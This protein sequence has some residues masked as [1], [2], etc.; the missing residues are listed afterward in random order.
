MSREKQYSR[1]ELLSQAIAIFRRNGYH[2]TSTAELTR[3]LGINKK[4][5][6]AEFG[7]KLQ[8]FE[9]TLV[10]YDRTFLT[11]MLRPIEEQGA[12]AE[13]IK[14]VFQQIAEY[15]Q[16]EL[17]GLGCLLCNTSAERG[18]LHAC[19]GPAI[20]HYYERINNGLK[21]ALKNYVSS[22]KKAKQID[23]NS[24]AGF[25]TT[26]L[27]GMATSARA[28]APRQQLQATCRFIETYLDSLK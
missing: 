22:Q 26:T 2:A 28:E 25:L 1:E 13:G 9:N 21:H 23:V 10:Y 3:E 14:K 11:E 27:I 16:K 17:K 15:G 5:M 8:F 4:T 20:D 24:I 6:Y 19:I 12:S 7:S 18:S